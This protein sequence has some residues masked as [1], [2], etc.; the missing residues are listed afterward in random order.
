MLVAMEELG[1]AE[2]MTEPEGDVVSMTVVVLEGETDA[3]LSGSGP[4]VTV[5]LTRRFETENVEL[6]SLSLLPAGQS[7][8]PGTQP[9]LYH[10][11]DTM[12]AP[13][14][15]IVSTT[16]ALDAFDGSGWYWLFPTPSRYTTND[17]SCPNTPF[18]CT[19]VPGRGVLDAQPHLSQFR[20]PDTPSVACVWVVVANM[21][22]PLFSTRSISIHGRAGLLI[23]Q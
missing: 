15:F 4:F 5:P 6:A 3:H 2:V 8:F 14:R 10:C 13:S 18:M 19:G 22:L 1:N 20:L 7:S 12:A 11:D 9:E 23:S 17:P 21:Q 16:T